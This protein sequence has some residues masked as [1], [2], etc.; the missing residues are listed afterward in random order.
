MTVSEK[1]NKIFESIDKKGNMDRFQEAC[2]D[3]KDMILSC[4]MQS[5]CYQDH[6]N[7]K[8][9]LQEGIDNDCKSL[10]YALF[11]CK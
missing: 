1:I 4:V 2:K 5:K 10:R 11:L 8:Y 6:N 7:F 9:C 3:E